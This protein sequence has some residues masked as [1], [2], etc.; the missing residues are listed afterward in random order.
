M[1]SLSEAYFPTPGSPAQPLE[2]N[3]PIMSPALSPPASSQA[4]S[5]H[6]G[7]LPAPSS[8]PVSCPFHTCHTVC[9]RPPSPADRWGVRGCGHLETRLFPSS[10]LLPRLG[11]CAES[12]TARSNR[13]PERYG[14]VKA[15][16]GSLVASATDH[17]GSGRRIGLQRPLI[18]GTEGPP[19]FPAP[20]GMKTRRLLEGSG[21]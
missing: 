13:C 10:S 9:P 14:G 15:G 8:T 5:V 1:C 16:R 11:H 3:F 18:L 21:L 6:P 2:S 19:A 17:L 7:E 12:E 20:L 4:P